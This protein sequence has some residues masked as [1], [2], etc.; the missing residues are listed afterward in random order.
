[1]EKEILEDIQRIEKT[2]K[3]CER[4][5][6]ESK[7]ELHK[8]KKFCIFGEGVIKSKDN[9]VLNFIAE[10]CFSGLDRK[11]TLKSIYDGYVSYCLNN[12]QEV[13]LS[14]RTFS[15]EMSELGY[16]IA[17]GTANKL[18]VHGIKLK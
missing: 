13:F 4:Y 3:S 18:Y 1:M 2:I 15:R 10:N 9:L 16:F 5:L 14:K 7:A 17:N 6:K 11:D 8:I 12:D